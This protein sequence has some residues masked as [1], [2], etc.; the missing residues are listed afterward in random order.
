M[1]SWSI[2]EDPGWDWNHVE[3]LI[4]SP[5]S[6]CWPGPLAG[7]RLILP[8]TV[9]LTRSFPCHLFDLTISIPKLCY[10]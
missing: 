8:G 1:G 9:S 4:S 2:P 3:T 5:P 6:G 10:Y 7:Y